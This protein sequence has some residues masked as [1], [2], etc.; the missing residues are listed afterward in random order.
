V[1]AAIVE[2]HSDQRWQIESIDKS[3]GL[4]TTKPAIDSAGE[5]MVCATKL[6][7]AH[8]TSLIVFVKGDG[9]G[10]ARES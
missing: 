6:D 10:L 2:T 1:W 8:E 5:S 9:H 4:I 3:S 7:E